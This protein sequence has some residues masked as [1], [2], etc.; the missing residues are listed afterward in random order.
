M[1]EH[2]VLDKWKSEMTKLIKMKY[3]DKY[4][5][6]EIE[7]KLNK[8]IDNKC[9]NR[10]VSLFNNYTNT[11]VR[12]T[13]LEL[14]D[15][16]EKN[17]LI[18]TGGGCIFLPHGTKP[19]ILIDF[20]IEIM[21]RRK[22]AKKMRKNFD[23]GTDGWL[24][25]DIAQLLNK[26]VINSLYGCMGYPGFALYNVFTAEAITAEGRHIIT[27]AINMVEGFVGGAFFF[28]DENELNHYIYNIS[29]EY[30]KYGTLNVSAFGVNDYLPLAY[31]KLISNSKF[32]MTENQKNSIMKMLKHK[33]QGEL[34]L[35]YYKNNLIEFS[36]LEVIRSKF[37]YIIQN[38]GL[39][40]F[41][42]MEL[43]K[44]DEMRKVTQDIWDL[45][46]IFVLY[47]YP[48]NDRIRKAMY[49]PKTRALYTDTDSVFVSVCHLV[50]Y[51]KHDVLHGNNP[52]ATDDDL[53]FTA[54]N[55]MLIFINIAIDRALKT[56][57]SSTNIEPEWAVKLGMK[58][59]FYLKRI[60][61]MEK[62]KRYI[63]LSILQEG[64]LL[65]GG[66]GKPEIKGIEFIKSTTK[67]YLRDYY[68]K[69]ATEEI[70]YADEISPNRIFKKMADLKADIEYGMSHGDSKF[71]KQSK[72][73]TP[74]N[75][76]NPFSTQGITA[77]MLWNT[78]CPN[79]QIELPADVNIVP[80][81]S[82]QQAK[83]DES[84]KT[85]PTQI[86]RADPFK[87]KNIAEL[88]EKYPEVYDRIY[89][90]IYTNTNPLIR[91]MNL[92][93]I[94]LPKNTDIEIP[95]YVFDLINY[96]DIVTNSIQLFLPVMDSLGIKSIPSTTNTSHM[97]N[98]I[99][100]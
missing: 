69:I 22:D 58:N 54:V 28:T 14:T 26:L 95:Q 80:I 41:C 8:V 96:D 29:E 81:K 64:Q 97:T 32:T 7:S 76:K 73:K 55:L 3:G 94:A 15:S 4:T 49:L 6:N 67:P 100:L 71:Y 88:A 60:L 66:K 19:N 30:A 82:L 21:K 53:T 68:T 10:P 72:V 11:S 87:N 44:D 91:Y 46:E 42:E 92:T 79:N 56:L 99:P 12:T 85:S 31:D 98:I 1:G 23:K 16:I 75:Y 74:D 43:L 5:K 70:L 36:K 45:Y 51:V 61:F 33:D 84:K 90:E 89:N 18:I 48:V 25:W 2:F 47:N 39:L 34:A 78:I 50:D 40:S 57:C 20:I 93:S 27:T 52:M 63:S 86:I 24:K 13:I 59:E 17:G 65:G 37:K 62:K 38:N 9:N 35:L 83:P 77:V